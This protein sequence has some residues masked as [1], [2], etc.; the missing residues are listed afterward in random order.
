MLNHK[1][2]VT[3]LLYTYYVYSTEGVAGEASYVASPG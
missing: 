3:T 1:L 2:L